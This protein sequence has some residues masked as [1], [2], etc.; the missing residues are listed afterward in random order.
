MRAWFW[1]EPAFSLPECYANGAH[2]DAK[3]H[4]LFSRA[5]IEQSIPARFEGQVLL[6]PS[7]VGIRT[8]ERCLTYEQ[9]NCAANRL[10]AA[11]LDRLGDVEEPVA[12][13]FD[14]GADAVIAILGVLKAGK[15]YLPLNTSYPSSRTAEQ[16][17]RSNA[18]LIVTGSDHAALGQS[19]AVS[20]RALLRMDQ[21]SPDW[22]SENPGLALSPDRKA[23]VFFTSG[24][25]GNPKGVVDNHRN[26][27][28]NIMRYTNNLH[29]VADDRLSLVQS[30]SFSGT[31]SSLF[32]ALL[33]GA[34][35]CPF[36]LT[37]EGLGS[38][39]SWL[40]D[41]E[42]TIYHSVPA[43][44]RSLVL[45]NRQFPSVRIVR[46]EGDQV[47][48]SDIDLYRKYLPSECLLAI[49]LGATET[50]LSSQFIIDKQGGSVS[51]VVPVGYPTLDMEIRILDELGRDTGPLVAGEIAV[52]SRYLAVGYWRRPDLET[53][54]FLPD[55]S[56]PKSRIYLT[57]DRGRLR[58][59]G[60][61]EFLG[62]MDG[63][64][65]IRSHWIELAEVDAAL[66]RVD[67]ISQAAASIREDV[68]GDPR[69]IGY[70]VA[71]PERDL[72]AAAI[73]T[74][75]ADELPD[76][77]I[78][79][80]FVFLD[81][82][83]LTESGKVDRAA[84]PAPAGFRGTAGEKRA[85]T[86]E[87]IEKALLAI[88]VEV[89]ERRALSVTD[90]FF[91]L[92]G[93]SLHAAI[94]CARVEQVFGKQT[95]AADLTAMP[96]VRKF[97]NALRDGI[98]ESELPALVPLQPRGSEP[99]L[100]LIHDHGGSAFRYF[101]LVRR[102]GNLRPCFGLQAPLRSSELG[103]MASI[104]ALAAFY[105]DQIES[106]QPAG[107]YHLGGFCIGG[108][109]AFEMARQLAASGRAV[110][111]LALFGVSPVDFPGVI[112][113]AS[114]RFWDL[115]L[116]RSGV[117]SEL[118]FHAARMQGLG[119][120][121]RWRYIR[122][123]VGSITPFVRRMLRREQA[124]R[125]EALPEVGVT[126]EARLTA[127]FDRY[128]WQPYPGPVDIFLS[129]YS[130]RLYSDDPLSD[131]SGLSTQSVNM[132]LIPLRVSAMLN[133]PYVQELAVQ[134]QGI[135]TIRQELLACCATP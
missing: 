129:T 39:A 61:L 40:R 78:P 103:N 1:I 121:A 114:Q 113:P 50:G 10:A 48:P 5:D 92:G 112:G 7:A 59:D 6:R 107:P 44:F 49:G 98:S 99:A 74:S 15:F 55:P 63:R 56:D 17:E 36:S 91:D 2:V 97:A 16:F 26:V 3:T 23:Y 89:L 124:S 73:R 34:S 4:Q 134:L 57:G 116:S 28:H 9:L 90:N 42:I 43:I 46:L 31:V 119:M 115:N 66:A 72:S 131:W 122:D 54:A 133:E 67:G 76:P 93:D 30:P 108:V 109:V 14:Q 94:I 118:R 71:S 86:R 96:T 47:I 84:L 60:C 88:W 62:R 22:N 110:G 11:L 95:A 29:I 35:V 12:L 37:R 8:R 52:R 123:R 80:Q 111:L 132:H 117:L 68:P 77:L 25:T 130:T 13:L 85:H 106:V 41:M 75:L 65:K 87:W 21:L 83:P 101:A 64:P 82:L 104:E 58:E 51:G 135:L 27:L 125:G 79:T 120:D 18:R 100:F 53:E 45:T 128:V 70:I 127:A 81:S 20:D 38:L 105:I 102:L 126:V 33:N 19:I 24:S 69:L 32:G